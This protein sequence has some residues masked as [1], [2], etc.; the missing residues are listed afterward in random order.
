MEYCFCVMKLV[1]S[2]LQVFVLIAALGGSQ[3]AAE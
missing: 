3:K 1:S 2:G